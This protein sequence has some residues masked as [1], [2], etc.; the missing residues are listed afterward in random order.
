MKH[1]F[2]AVALLG[3]TATTTL[4]QGVFP[5][6]PTAA[7]T[8]SG[9]QNMIAQTNLLE[10]SLKAHKT[11]Q[12]EAAAAEILKLMKKRVAQ[13]RYMAEAKT[14]SDRDALMQR[15]LMLEGRVLSFRDAAKDVNKNGQQLVTEARTYTN[16]Y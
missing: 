16:D 1:L 8:Q 6:P 15:M 13:T 5:P 9:K 14:G 2:L 7:E 12:A 10:S 3:A 11:A 4:A